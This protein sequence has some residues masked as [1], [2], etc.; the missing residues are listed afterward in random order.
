[1]RRE[2]TFGVARSGQYLEVVPAKS[3]LVVLLQEYVRL[4]AAG[5]RY[6]GLATGQQ[7]LEPTRAGD[8]IRVHVRVHCNRKKHHPERSSKRASHCCRRTMPPRREIV[9]SRNRTF[10]NVLRGW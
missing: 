7:R 1:V 6:H 2:L 8:V 10:F 9:A 3:D 5:A 4:G